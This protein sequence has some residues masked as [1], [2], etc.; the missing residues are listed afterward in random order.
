[1]RQIETNQH[2]R[3]VHSFDRKK[4]DRCIL[5]LELEKE[6][7]FGT[8]PN[9]EPLILQIWRQF[10]MSV[11]AGAEKSYIKIQ[12]CHPPQTTTYPLCTLY[13]IH[14]G[15]MQLDMMQY[16]YII[17]EQS[18]RTAICTPFMHRISNGECPQPA[19]RSKGQEIQTKSDD[20]LWNRPY[21]PTFRNKKKQ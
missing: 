21:Q 19:L 13:D 9:I 2:Q 3:Y 14:T 16:C 7:H 20:H 12:P 10:T 1:M 18:S 11:E 5:T 6:A 8:I 15:N 17:M 4:P